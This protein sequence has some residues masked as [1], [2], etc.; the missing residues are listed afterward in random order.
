M[1]LVRWKKL[2]EQ[3]VQKNPWWTY[4]RDEFEIPGKKKGE[5][6]Y[7]HTNGSSLVIPMFDDGRLLLVN[8]YRYLCERESLEFP[9]GGVKNGHTHEETAVQELAEEA[10]YAARNWDL[11]GEFNPY[12]GVTNEFCRVYL[13][14][15]LVPAVSRPD[16]TEEFERVTLTSDDVD[17]RILS[18]VMWDGMSIAGWT[19]AKPHL[20]PRID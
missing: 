4:R 5:Y 16:D 17:A 20:P 6:Y 3:V 7:V 13:A 1:P 18:G 11:L 8:Q 10:G 19:I 9:C 14:R 2:K 12:N 15:D